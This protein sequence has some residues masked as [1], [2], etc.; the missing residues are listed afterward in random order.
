MHNLRDSSRFRFQDCSNEANNN[1]M[2]FVTCIRDYE[3]AIKRD[4]E[5]LL[6]FVKENLH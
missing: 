5:T 3:S 1:I 6:R 2:K 4:N